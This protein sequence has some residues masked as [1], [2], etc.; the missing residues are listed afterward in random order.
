[1][2]SA[3]LGR[4]APY[5]AV[6][7][8]V[9]ALAN[10]ALGHELLTVEHDLGGAQQGIQTQAADDALAGSKAAR[11]GQHAADL[12]TIDQLRGAL[13]REQSAADSRQDVLAAL[14]AQLAAIN[15]SIDH[16]ITLTPEAAAWGAVLLPAAVLSDDSLCWYDPASGWGAACGGPASANGGD[17]GS[18]H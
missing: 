11:A 14:Q 7:L 6:A 5:L 15:R 18:R 3:I 1:M 13:K 9:S 2:I 8:L 12:G 4:I 17:P 16:D 10:W